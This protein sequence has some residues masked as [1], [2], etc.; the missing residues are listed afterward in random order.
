MLIIAQK[1]KP[2]K[3]KLY[4]WAFDEIES[5]TLLKITADEAKEI[6]RADKEG[7][8]NETIH[9]VREYVREV[10]PAIQK[11]WLDM[12]AKHK[13]ANTD[14]MDVSKKYAINLE[15]TSSL[16]RDVN[17]HTIRIAFR[18]QGSKKPCNINVLYIDNYIREKFFDDAHHSLMWKLEHKYGI[19]V[20]DG[21]IYSK[22]SSFMNESYK[23][24]IKNL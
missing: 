13:S 11:V 17:T 6:I 7:W 8:V 14:F 10:S 3:I 21:S 22:W 12:V 19:S 20:E 15:G 16:I 24:V 4:R 1:V 18:K 23:K 5:Y 9:G 2:N